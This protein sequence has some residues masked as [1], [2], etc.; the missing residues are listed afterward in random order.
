MNTT[1]VVAQLESKFPGKKIVIPYPTNPTEIIC[2]TEPATNHPEWSECVAVIEQS[3]PHKHAVTEEVYEVI[4]GELTITC[5]GEE[6]VRHQ[7]ERVSVPVGKV[8]SAK[9]NPVV[10]V[11][12]FSK[13]GWTPEDHEVC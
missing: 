11:R 2:E 9:G 8:H 6:F 1:D 13:P 4:E 12:V 10:W 7:R 3:T 5:D